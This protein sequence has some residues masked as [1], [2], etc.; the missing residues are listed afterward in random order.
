MGKEVSVSDSLNNRGEAIEFF[1]HF[2]TAVFGSID[3][4]TAPLNRG[5]FFRGQADVNWPLLP[6]IARGGRESIS[7]FHDLEKQVMEHFKALSLPYIAE[8]PGHDLDWLVMAQHYGLSTRL[9]DWTDNPLVALYFCVESEPGKDGKVFFTRA[10]ETDYRKLSFSE[11]I[12]TSRFMIN[13]GKDPIKY[14]SGFLDYKVERNSQIYFRPHSKNARY[15]NQ[16][17]VLC[18]NANPFYDPSLSQ[19]SPVYQ[20]VVRKELKSELLKYL[21][22]LGIT[23]AHIYP[24]LEGVARY[25]KRSLIDNEVIRNPGVPF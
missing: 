10:V 20:M 19:G 24:G 3:P 2:M 6:S 14:D 9:T 1:S 13:S 15:S 7:N 21:Y 4:D 17:S 5:H 22:T 11:M 16:G 23:E 25:I 12:E 8:P 18:W